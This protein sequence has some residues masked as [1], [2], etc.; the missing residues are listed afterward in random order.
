[1]RSTDHRRCVFLGRLADELHH[2]TGRDASG[3]YLDPALV[4]PLARRQHVVDHTGWRVAGVGE[5]VDLGPDFLRLARSGLHLVRLGEHHGESVVILP[6]PF[7]REL[8]LM[9]QRVAANLGK[10]ER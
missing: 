1:M 4:V 5:G 2:V 8:G 3:A 10:A 7:V 6:A 9:L